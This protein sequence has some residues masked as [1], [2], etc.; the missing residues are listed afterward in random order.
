MPVFTKLVLILAQWL[1]AILE[2][3]KTP[4]CALS[5]GRRQHFIL[6][7]GTLSVSLHL[8]DLKPLKSQKGLFEDFSLRVLA[9]CRVFLYLYFCEVSLD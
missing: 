8:Q 6:C 2:L 4:V 3:Q 9:R 7:K 5:G 1:L